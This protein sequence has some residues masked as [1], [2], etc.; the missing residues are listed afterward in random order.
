MWQVLMVDD[1]PTVLMVHGY[2]ADK[3]QL[4]D[5]RHSFEE[6]QAAIDY[7][8]RQPSDDTRYLVLLDI[9]MPVLNGWGFLDALHNRPFAGQVQVV[10]VTSSIAHEDQ[11]KAQQYPCV[12]RYM[13]KPLLPERLRELKAL[14]VST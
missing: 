10:M 13:V 11:L 12:I 9:N 1:D 5:V 4:G 3:E 6:G 8:D 7:L 2:L 14:Y